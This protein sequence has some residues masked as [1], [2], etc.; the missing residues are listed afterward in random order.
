[1]GVSRKVLVDAVLARLGTV[2]NATGWLMKPDGPVPVKDGTDGIVGPHWLLYPSPGT[3][4]PELDLGD[5]VVDVDMVLQVTCVT[6]DPDDL[7]PLITRI[8]DALYRW[9]PTITGLVCGPLRPPPGYDP[10]P[11]REDISVKPSRFW[12]PLQYVLPATAT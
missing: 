1:M 12:V 2:T 6:G 3:P 9:T 10:G 4:G 8:D 7:P 11:A 5:T